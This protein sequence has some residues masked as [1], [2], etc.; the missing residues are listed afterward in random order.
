MSSYG[1]YN[2]QYSFDLPEQSLVEPE[3]IY[4]KQKPMI[5]NHTA[6]VCHTEWTVGGSKVEG[7]KLTNQELTGR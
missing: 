2:P 3:G 6:A 1:L 4:D 5:K 7:K